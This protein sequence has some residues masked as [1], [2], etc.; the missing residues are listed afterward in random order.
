MPPLP[1]TLKTRHETVCE[2][3]A[4]VDTRTCERHGGEVRDEPW[5]G[6]SSNS[7]WAKVGGPAHKLDSPAF[8]RPLNWGAALGTQDV[9]TT[10]ERE[11][12]ENEERVY[13]AFDE[14][15][16]SWRAYD[17]ASSIPPIVATLSLLA[18]GD[19]RVAG[20]C[21]EAGIGLVRDVLSS[22]KVLEENRTALF[23]LGEALYRVHLKHKG[24]LWASVLEA[25][26]SVARTS[27]AGGRLALREK[28]RGFSVPF[29]SAPFWRACEPSVSSLLPSL[30]AARLAFL[31]AGALKQGSH[32]LGLTI[33]KETHG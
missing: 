20:D 12:L 21:V 25:C 31:R 13:F 30:E 19:A 29:G 2:G 14:G 23:A 32:Q 16:T 10:T 5:R 15:G 4:V 26:V 1:R 27:E 28:I 8:G 17:S 7:L 22:D 9:L 11:L 6:R 24:D 3:I 18:V 33:H